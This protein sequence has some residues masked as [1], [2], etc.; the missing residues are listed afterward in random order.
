MSRPFRP[1][2]L[3]ALLLALAVLAGCSRPGAPARVSVDWLAA[4]A[5]PA[6]D[7]DGPPDALRAALERHLSIGLL[8]RDST[9][10]TRLGL[11]ASASVSADSLVWTFRLRDGLRYTDGSPLTSADIQ[12][13]LLAGLGRR[14]HATREW[15]LAAVARERGAK[16]GAGLAIVCPDPRTLRITLAR[17]DPRLLDKLAVSGV[18]APF[19]SRV[20]EWAQAVGAGPYRVIAGHE[21][22]SLTL[23]ASGPV[24]GV[25]PTADTLRIRFT[26]GAARALNAMRHGSADVVW[27]L[28]PGL[29]GQRL[30]RE[31]SVHQRDPQPARRLYLV[32][33]PEAAPFGRLEARN[34]LASTF[35]REDVLTALGARGEP[36]RRWLP[37]A[38]ADYEWPRIES[39]A[40]R[41]ARSL[42][43]AAE[44]EDRSRSGEPART[45]SYHVVLAY[46]A[47]G[48]GAEVAR[49]LQGQWARAGHY[50]ELRP[51]RGAEV[52]EEMLASGRS[53][54]RLVESQAPLTGPEA[55]V[56][57]LVLPLRGPAVG[58]FRSGWRTRDLDRWIGLPEASP[59]F[60]PTGVQSM[61]ARERVVL[62]LAT[63]PWQWA[64]RSGGKP[65][66]VQ[67]ATGPGWTVTH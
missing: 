35:N 5:A 59:G 22:H 54:A 36:V 58:S 56:A 65:P 40:E 48:A 24:A 4:H 12:R 34:T 27:P 13:A 53:Q 3:P 44:H 63:I 2:S 60:D 19:K 37:G 28:A 42:Q 50:A 31:W 49:S 46:D 14:D 23:V 15:L 20:G 7:P 1:G 26:I 62:P 32:L 29:L 57:T 51:R 47:D 67:A 66:V 39:V 30:P 41:A 61:L 6:F 55:E 8:D 18:S 25:Q 11:A 16:A 38:E 33:R 52:A 64:T 10:T 43:A 9:G 45:R 17:P 21:G